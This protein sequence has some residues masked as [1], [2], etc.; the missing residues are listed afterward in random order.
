MIIT[1]CCLIN[2][3]LRSSLVPNRLFTHRFISFA[4][5]VFSFLVIFALSQHPQVMPTVAGDS[6][7]SPNSVCTRFSLVQGRNAD[8]GIGHQGTFVMRE[9]TTGSTLA[10]WEVTGQETVSDWFINLPQVSNGASWVEV[11]FELE[12]GYE[13]LSP[14][15]FIGHSVLL[16]ILNPAPDTT[17][18]WVANGQ[19]HSVEIQFDEELKIIKLPTPS[20]SGGSSGREPRSG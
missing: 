2:Q 11:R 9:V 18:G 4:I 1:N 17:Y 13:F 19:C 7:T 20:P 5:T 15:G 12:E 16:E 3:I 10:T 8:T 6:Q 14:E